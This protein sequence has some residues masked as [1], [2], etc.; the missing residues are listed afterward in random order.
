MSHRFA[1]V[2]RPRSASRRRRPSSSTPPTVRGP[3]SRRSSPPSPP[4]PTA[5]CSSCAQAPT[6]APPSSASGP[7]AARPTGGAA[8]RTERHR[9]AHRRPRRTPAGVGAR[10]P[11]GTRAEPRQGRHRLPQQPGC[12]DARVDPAGTQHLQHTPS[13][14][15]RQRPAAVPR[16]RVQR[17][18]RIVDQQC[19]AGRLRTHRQRHRSTWPPGHR[20]HG[21]DRQ[22]HR[23]RAA[24]A[25]ATPAARR[26]R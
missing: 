6:S 21:A 11:A 3:S 22:R 17:H 14:R 26:S 25:S 7:Y 19:G 18:H 2:L 23:D 1:I 9:V 24:S 15:D 5:P 8:G 16:A 10:V 13:D 4:C 12:G 20:R